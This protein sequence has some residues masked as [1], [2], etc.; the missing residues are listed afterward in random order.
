MRILQFVSMEI[1][2]IYHFA[3]KLT[4]FIH[5]L[6]MQEL[7]MAEAYRHFDHESHTIKDPF[8]IPTQY[9]HM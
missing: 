8:C 9:T 2:I 7:P 1:W 5:I 3:L 6:H 4:L